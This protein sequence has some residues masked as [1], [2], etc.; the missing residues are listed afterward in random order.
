[1]QRS[2]PL[3]YEIKDGEARIH[4]SE[5]KMIHFAFESY[6]QGDSQFT[7]AKHFQKAGYKNGNGRVSWSHSTIGKLLQNKA[8]LGDNFYPPLISQEKFDKAAEVRKEKVAHQKRSGMMT[9]NIVNPFL[10]LVLNYPAIFAA[11]LFTGFK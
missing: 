10:L 5:A 9:T 6:C 7:I 2:I 11:A 3:G 4:D 1:M 8:Y